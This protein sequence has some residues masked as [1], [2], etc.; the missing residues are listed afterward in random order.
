MLWDDWTHV[1]LLQHALASQGNDGHNLQLLS[2]GVNK[3]IKFFG[4]YEAVQRPAAELVREL[5]QALAQTHRPRR[6]LLWPWLGLAGLLAIA[7][8]VACA[9]WFAAWKLPAQWIVAWWRADLLLVDSVTAQQRAACL[10]EL[11]KPGLQM[12]VS[13]LADPRDDVRR[14]AADVLLAQVEQWKRLP[15][16]EASRRVAIVTEELSRVVGDLPGDQ[17]QSIEHLVTDLLRWPLDRSAVDCVAIVA[18]CERTLAALERARLAADA[19]RGEKNVNVTPRGAAG[20]A[21]LAEPSRLNEQRTLAGQQDATG[22]GGWEEDPGADQPTNGQRVPDDQSPAAPV[23]TVADGE[24][25]RPAGV[26]RF[27][28]DDQSPD[29]LLGKNSSL[30]G[31]HSSPA[32]PDAAYGQERSNRSSSEASGSDTAHLTPEHG[33]SP[34]L[35]PLAPRHAVP[36]NPRAEDPVATAVQRG[37]PVTQL[38]DWHLAQQLKARDAQRVLAATEELRRRGFSGRAITVLEM[39]VDDD[40][41][42]RLHA[43][44]EL[45]NVSDLRPIPWLYHMLY[46]Q[47]A[48]VRRRA[49]AMLAT[50]PVPETVWH[51]NQL[52]NRETDRQV[53]EVLDHILAER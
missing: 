49:V 53:L 5:V 15:L 46:D 27:V 21:A 29:A 43:L 11:G 42:V 20:P 6:S 18:H 32:N 22:G 24:R 13:M 33:L 31:N 28:S 52:R 34:G 45:A 9:A 37:L 2:A 25:P 16:A 1:G 40:P 12:L 39:L 48:T 41:Q 30:G 8:G 50:S 36:I 3:D 23:L 51:L 38:S 26:R 7:T 35:I 47:D 44:A 17:W 19:N 10:P 14:A 4:M